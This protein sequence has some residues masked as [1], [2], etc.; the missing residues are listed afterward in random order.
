ME[1]TVKKAMIAVRVT[2]SKKKYLEEHYGAMLPKLIN[3]HLDK[4][5]SAAATGVWPKDVEKLKSVIQ[6]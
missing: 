4:M 3:A 1:R 6:D 2:E 5:V